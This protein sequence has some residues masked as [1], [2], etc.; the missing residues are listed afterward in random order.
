[1]WFSIFRFWSCRDCC[2]DCCMKGPTSFSHDVASCTHEIVF[3][4][5]DSNV[6]LSH[7]LYWKG[8]SFTL[9]LIDTPVVIDIKMSIGNSLCMQRDQGRPLCYDISAKRIDNWKFVLYYRLISIFALE[10]AGGAKNALS[11]RRRDHSFWRRNERAKMVVSIIFALDNS[12]LTFFHFW[13][14]N[15][16]WQST[17]LNL[18]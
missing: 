7:M 6:I 16:C 8:I 18:E 5:Y 17:F 15:G 1:M 4:L 3:Q 12:A 10:E 2:G 9:S 14:R 11:L 13:S